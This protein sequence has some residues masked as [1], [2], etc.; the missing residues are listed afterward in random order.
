MNPLN[1]LIHTLLFVSV[2]T[3]AFINPE[4]HSGFLAFATPQR[5]V[6]GY[7]ASDP[8]LAVVYFSSIFDTQLQPNVANPSGPIE[9]EFNEYLKG[10]FE[11]NGKANSPV[12]CTIFKSVSL[13]KAGRSDHEN[14][15]RQEK[16]QVVEVKW[17]YTPDIAEYAASYLRP[18]PGITSPN[19]RTSR[20]THTYCL[21]E[22]SRG[23]VFSTG[24]VDTDGNANYAR[25]RHGF[26]MFLRKKYDFWGSVYC[27]VA[28]VTDVQR[29]MNAHIE[30][31]HAAG[32]KVVDTGW[33]Y[34]SV[35]IGNMP[36]PPR[37]D[38]DPEP[39]QRQLLKTRELAGKEWPQ[40]LA[41]CRKDRFL[42]AVFRCDGFSQVVYNY[43]VAHAGDAGAKWESLASLVASDKLN[44]DTCIDKTRVGFWVKKHATG[45][46]LSTLTTDCI[47]RNVITTFY[48]RPQPHLLK[49][50][51]N[52]AVAACNK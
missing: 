5:P 44:C 4:H 52:E 30:G 14:R 43:R 32:V 9:N 22:A 3:L 23:I 15:M 10:R 31:A 40:S 13:A 35:E 16:K 42:S 24:P 33:R 28:P 38:Y 1:I 29:L 25:W 36:Q 17:R 47:T 20:P 34:F 19:D 45:E 6:I 27:N 37:Q 39:I 50:F 21:S 18:G 49:L 12:E 41:Y 48:K 46:R 51:F 7:C 8:N 11:F 26:S 2:V